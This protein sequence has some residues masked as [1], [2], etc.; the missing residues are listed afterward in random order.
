MHHKPSAMTQG[1]ALVSKA[2]FQ[3]KRPLKLVQSGIARWLL[4]ILYES[5]SF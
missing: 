5:G 1:V 2:F 4:V 3:R